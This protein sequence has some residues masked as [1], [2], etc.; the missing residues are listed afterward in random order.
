MTYLFTNQKRNQR[1]FSLIELM[2]V[3]A[4]IGLLAAIAIPQYGRF[5]KRAMQTEAKS[6][7]SGFICSTK[8]FYN[9]MEFCVI[10]YGTVRICC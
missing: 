3:V 6:G 2:V 5:Q 10:K 9:R 7:L 1:G 4:I 8:D